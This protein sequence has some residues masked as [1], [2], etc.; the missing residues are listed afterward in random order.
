MRNGLHNKAVEELDIMIDRYIDHLIESNDFCEIFRKADNLVEYLY[1]LYE[2]G[3]III[4]LEE[5][6]LN[7][8]KE[9]DNRFTFIVDWDDYYTYQNENCVKIQ[10]YKCKY[11][12]TDY[13]RQ[14]LFLQYLR[15]KS[16]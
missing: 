10:C 14:K 4:R 15:E 13:C 8:N 16:L 9:N 5:K 11:N 2:V 3:Y 12:G 6:H 7:V 1:N